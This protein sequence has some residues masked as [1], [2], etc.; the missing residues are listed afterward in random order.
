MSVSLGRVEVGRRVA[1]LADDDLILPAAVRDEVL[2]LLTIL[3]AHR[4]AA[5]DSAPGSFERARWTARARE[6][7]DRIH[8][9]L[10]TGRSSS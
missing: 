7:Q 1:V 5:G 4:Q 6:V 3:G 9:L 8:R 10:T 2:A